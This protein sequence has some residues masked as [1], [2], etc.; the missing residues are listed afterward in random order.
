[1]LLIDVTPR[2]TTWCLLG[3]AERLEGVSLIPEDVFPSIERR[4]GGLR[5]PGTVGYVLHHGGELVTKPVS[6]VTP[7]S[8]LAVQQCGRFLPEHSDA[9]HKVIEFG[10]AALPDAA[11]LL[12]CETAFFRDLPEFVHTYAVPLSLKD[13]SLRRYGADGLCHEWVWETLK[14]RTPSL[15]RVVSVLLGEN[16]NVAAIKDGKAVETTVGFT[17]VEGISTAHGC[18]DI[19]PTIVFQVQSTGLS[20]GDISRLLTRQSGFSGFLGRETS[21]T[22]IAADG[23]RDPELAR[24][25]DVLLYQI[26]KY[27]GAFVSVLGGVD[28]VAF[29]SED[30]DAFGNLVRPLAAGLGYLGARIAPKAAEE[31]RARRLSSPDSPVAVVGLAYDKWEDLERRAE[32]FRQKQAR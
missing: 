23:G 14:R 31:G 29:V 4:I 30:M 5:D 7:E 17:P 3:G 12:L 26:A 9:L 2:S 13:P 20:F 18:G 10:L 6:A 19:D 24:V 1:M 15:S 8:L 11:H 27:L 32:G 16:A 21:I 25:M 28:A 22:E